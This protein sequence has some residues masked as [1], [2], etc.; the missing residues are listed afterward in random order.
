M[1]LEIS[2]PHRPTSYHQVPFAKCDSGDLCLHLFCGRLWAP[3]EF[4]LSFSPRAENCSDRQPLRSNDLC[5]LTVSFRGPPEASSKLRWS[6]EAYSLSESIKMRPIV[7][8]IEQTRAMA[9]PNSLCFLTAWTH[10]PHLETKSAP[11]RNAKYWR[12]CLSGYSAHCSS[13]GDLSL[14]P[15]R[16]SKKPGIDIYT[17]TL[18]RKT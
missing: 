13:I 7:L 15:Q 2:S 17:F 5:L 8:S 18:R 3:I 6:A 1:S 11:N 10:Q 14:D 12:K 4:V 9:L 16:P